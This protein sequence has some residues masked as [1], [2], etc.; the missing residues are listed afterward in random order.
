[1]EYLIPALILVAGII[2]GGLALRLFFRA[3]LS[4]AS[5]KIRGDYERRIAVLAERLAAK[6]A[7]ASDL[8]K[9]ITRQKEEKAL[10][11][12]ALKSN[13]Q[14]FLEVAKSSFAKGST[15][16]WGKGRMQ[17]NKW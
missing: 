10:S 17:L 12:E 6:E 4:E 8:S 3:K 11:A 16:I 13:N 5:Q 7:A 1:M 14:M 2:I 15:A 9:E